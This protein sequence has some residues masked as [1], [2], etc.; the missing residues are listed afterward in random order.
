M[1]K[2]LWE[3]KIRYHVDKGT[4]LVTIGEK[5]ELPFRISVIGENA[6]NILR[7]AIN[8]V[9]EM[10]FF[11]LVTSMKRFAAK[12]ILSK[13]YSIYLEKAY[14]FHRGE[15]YIG[16]GEEQFSFDEVRD[17]FN[18]ICILVQEVEAYLKQEG[19]L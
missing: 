2:D 17:I 19:K 10:N 9:S 18:E 7:M 12:G 15:T 4:E 1:Y 6:I 3:S 11:M 14:E 8:G 16:S 5:R 13:D